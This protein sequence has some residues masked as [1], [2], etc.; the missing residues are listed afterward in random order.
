MPTESFIRRGHSMFR[1]RLY[2][3]H[4]FHLVLFCLK[5]QVSAG[6]RKHLAMCQLSERLANI[7]ISGGLPRL[8][9]ETSVARSLDY[10]RIMRG[11][12]C[13]PSFVCI[14][15]EEC[16]KLLK[17]LGTPISVI[18][19]LSQHMYPGAFASLHIVFSSNPNSPKSARTIRYYITA[20]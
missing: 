1:E 13:P 12:R 16:Q 5:A 10:A 8:E 15:I 20:L 11:V 19:I 6:G 18:A 14:Y 17:Y 2:H 7:N 3:G 9:S 4:H